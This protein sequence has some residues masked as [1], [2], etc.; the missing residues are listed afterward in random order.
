MILREYL[1]KTGE[2]WYSL[3]YG[4]RLPVRVSVWKREDALASKH[5]VYRLSTRKRVV[6]QDDSHSRI[7]KH[8]E[9]VCLGISRRFQIVASNMRTITYQ[10]LYSP[11]RVVLCDAVDQGFYNPIT[12]LREQLG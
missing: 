9:T 3:R 5:L 6:I 7:A 12:E 1:R 10:I 8:V 2:Y 4:I 11:T